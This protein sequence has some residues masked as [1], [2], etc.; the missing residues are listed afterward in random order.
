MTSDS[1]RNIL[2]I[3]EYAKKKMR[4][5]TADLDIID[6]LIESKFSFEKFIKRNSVA[7]EIRVQWFTNLY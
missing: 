1:F 5:H 4:K 7:R 6:L 3:A 2:L